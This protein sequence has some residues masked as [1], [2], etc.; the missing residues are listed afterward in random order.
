MPP[1]SPRRFDLV[2]C[3]ATLL[4]RVAPTQTIGINSET[5]FSDP[6]TGGQM[7]QVVTSANQPFYSHNANTAELGE[8][9]GNA[10]SRNRFSL[11]LAVAANT[12]AATFVPG[13]ASETCGV[14]LRDLTSSTVSTTAYLDN[15]S[16]AVVPKPGT[17]WGGAALRRFAWKSRRQRQ[18]SQA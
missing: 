9:F 7:L 10:P 2:A 5:A 13:A 4:A 17:A 3:A 8:T 15:L 18:S 14:S 1:P 11:Q 12:A 6:A 16:I